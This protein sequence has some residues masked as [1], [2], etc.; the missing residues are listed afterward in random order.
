M[1]KYIDS[2]PKEPLYADPN[3]P[4][5]LAPVGSN[6]YASPR[7]SGESPVESP[8][9]Q[10]PETS[11]SRPSAYEEIDPTQGSKTP[12]LPPSVETDGNSSELPKLPTLFLENHA[13]ER[14]A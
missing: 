8:K 4:E 3:E 11:R 10:D 12:D 13:F 6:E 9:S 1:K 7:S 2:G 5:K 14:D